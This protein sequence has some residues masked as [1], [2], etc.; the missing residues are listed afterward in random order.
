M[1]ETFDPYYRWF[2]IPPAEQ[3]PN[4]YRLLGITLFEEQADAIEA[5]AEQRMVFLRNH[6]LGKHGDLT[7]RLLN[8]V[9]TAQ[10]CL[11]DPKKK[12]EYDERL[13]A[14][15]A[16]GKA[17]SA[18]LPVAERL[19]DED[20]IAPDVALALAEVEV[21]Q[22][23]PLRTQ[24]ERKAV[25]K[26]PTPAVAAW[27][28]F[29]PGKEQ[30]IGAALVFSAILAVGFYLGLSNR[31]LQPKPTRL[32]LVWPE[33]ERKG[34]LFDIN[35]QP[36][37]M[38][39]LH[40]G[41]HAGELV[42]V[43]KPG[44]YRIR[45][46]RL[47]CT[48]YEKTVPLG[49]GEVVT[50]GPP[51]LPPI[52]PAPPTGPGL[53]ADLFG[54]AEFNNLVKERVDR[55]VNWIWDE[56]M[57]DEQITAPRFSIRWSGWLK[58]P[59]F[60]RYRFFL[61]A[62]DT[63]SLWLDG[64]LIVDAAKP[65]AE[66]DLGGK[67]CAIKIEYRNSG[68]GAHVV[69]QWA[70]LGLG[71][72]TIQ[73][74]PAEVLFCDQ[75]S[76][77]AAKVDASVLARPAGATPEKDS[78]D[79][80]KLIDPLKH[81]VAGHWWLE[82]GSLVSAHRAALLQVP[83]L[84]PSEYEVTIV[85]ERLEGTDALV[86]GLLGEGRPLAVVI[87]GWG[88][89]TSTS[90]VD[91]VDAVR[92][93]DNETAHPGIVIP[94]GKPVTL[95]YTVRRSKFTL[96]R[97]GETIMQ[98]NADYRRCTPLGDWVVP[99]MPMLTLATR[100]SIFRITRF[101]LKPL[102][103]ERQPIPG[104][105]PQDPPLTLV[106][107][108]GNSPPAGS[109]GREP[110]Q[111]T[112][113]Y[114]GQGGL[115]FY[116]LAPAGGLLV[117]FRLSEKDVINSIQPLYRAAGKL[118]EGRQYGTPSGAN[119]ELLA[120]DGYAIGEVNLKTSNA[121]HG[122]GVTYRPI[123]GGHLD[124]ASRQRSVW[125]GG[126]GGGREVQLGNGT[127][128]YGIH[129]AAARNLDALGLIVAP[130]PE[131]K[132]AGTPFIRLVDLRPLWARVGSD[133][134]RVNQYFDANAWPWAPSA[135]QT[136]NE[137][138]CARAPSRLVY[139]IPPGTKSFTVV[140]YC[141]VPRIC[142]KVNVDGRPLHESRLPAGVASIRVDLPADAKTIEL[143]ADY[144]PGKKDWNG[145][146]SYWLF[147]R[148]HPVGKEQAELDGTGPHTKLTQ[149]EPDTVDPATAMLQVNQPPGNIWPLHLTEEKPCGE[150]LFAHAMS[151]LAYAVPEGAEEFSATGYCT[152]NVP[153]RF[154]VFADA[155]LL[156]SSAPAEIV[157]IRVRLPKGAQRLHLLTDDL[158][159]NNCKH[160]FWC[161][162]RFYGP[163]LKPVRPILY[164]S[165]VVAADAQS[166]YENAPSP[167]VPSPPPPVIIGP[168]APPT[169]IVD[170][171]APPPV[172]VGPPP[173][174]D[175][176]DARL[177][178]LRAL[179]P[180]V[181][182]LYAE[183]Q[184]TATA[185]AAAKKTWDAGCAQLQNDI[186]SLQQAI[187]K[188]Q[189]AQIFGFDSTRAA[190]IR[191]KQQELL[192]QTAALASLRQEINKPL[193]TVGAAQQ[194]SRAAEARLNVAAA[195]WEI[196]GDFLGKLGPLSQKR[197]VEQLTQ[198]ISEQNLPHLYS[199]RAFALMYLREYDRA[200]ED[201]EQLVRLDPSPEAFALARA[202]R[203]YIRY[204]QGRRAQGDAEFQKA[205]KLSPMLVMG[206]LLHGKACMELK[207]YGPAK[208]EYEAALKANGIAEAY[209]SLAWL[210]AVCP[211]DSLRNPK[212][213]M[214]YATEA[215]RLARTDKRNHTDSWSY[216]DTLG[217][218]NAA[219]GNFV[220]AIRNVEEAISQAPEEN[221]AALRQQE[222]L[223]K[224]GQSCRLD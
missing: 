135:P 126:I 136:C 214:D 114:G 97:D 65:E 89:N 130:P 76:A 178:Q 82:G 93:F 105:T 124:A 192:K 171:T 134:L 204:Q 198:W 4:H 118:V 148:F 88:R 179:Y 140:G 112:A 145:D 45:I 131:S 220:E 58:P 7:Q 12:V 174:T 87:D 154:R 30:A 15:G 99:G 183:M 188:L 217:A 20:E 86:L 8:E 75:A 158:G 2:G 56:R 16:S 206:R 27:K 167:V 80:L 19:P 9:A 46:K 69:F 115:A 25:Q 175:S 182:R 190:D 83:F 23:H 10:I 84:P 31:S 64:K 121:V 168:P 103:P 50:I 3:P 41:E 199:A 152:L 60:G 6:Q 203:G 73:P 200:S 151:H 166:P 218:A 191:T 155:S 125:V 219:A 117:G 81:T 161:Y 36:Q 113:P 70:C 57:P 142:Y 164:G 109:K 32:I 189:Q 44:Q 68:I 173:A 205:T 123:V 14:D 207:R 156:L 172:I 78:L 62:K 53:A 119:V 222:I 43:T 34:A 95:K 149:L 120:K 47:M 63:A 210:L 185:F 157:P 211:A 26:R 29:L 22:P 212:L 24:P 51:V 1:S 163:S 132:D 11:L 138:L 35:D 33:A 139:K 144:P 108:P 133:M 122:L 110:C 37:D 13:C 194:S 54:D 224:K 111:T 184:R 92:Y 146:Q 195:D 165:P 147:P 143:A 18:V 201:L 202:A 213:A 94:A 177:E 85:V 71:A 48:D 49:P 59:V 197:A 221:R 181:T 129:G 116:D 128:I 42:L 169:V 52:P 193:T 160:T 159:D 104:D 90:G 153:A 40:R 141:P 187:A 98:W 66:V 61:P 101:E 96:V 216:L 180:Q 127:P 77:Q 55:Q 223:F 208:S 215:C 38:T 39:E 196:A 162:P 209:Q 107:G 106:S 176:P 21:R 79:L 17:S 67:P 186:G 91:L 100:P 150:F 102:S 137:F 170:P 5:A 28:A 74:V 72:S